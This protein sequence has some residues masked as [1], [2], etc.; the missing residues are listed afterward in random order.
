MERRKSIVLL[1][2]KVLLCSVCRNLVSLSGPA[3][4]GLGAIEGIA[5]EVEEETK[6]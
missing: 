3:S 2:S 1:V 4:R 5:Q 6:S